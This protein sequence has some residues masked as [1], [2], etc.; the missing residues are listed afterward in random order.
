MCINV[1]GSDL[2]TYEKI[3]GTQYCSW[4]KHNP[5]SW[6]V[7]GSIPDGVSEIFHSSNPSD[8]TVVLGSN[9]HLTKMSTRH[10]TWEIKATSA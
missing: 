6:K 2:P 5:T 4:L 8:L 1:T 7:A 3:G 9:Q 10:L